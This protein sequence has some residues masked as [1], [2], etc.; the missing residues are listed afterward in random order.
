MRI[1]IID[2]SGVAAVTADPI[3]DLQAEVRNLKAQLTEARRQYYV[4]EAALVNIR[5]YAAIGLFE[6]DCIAG[7]K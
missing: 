3:T 2:A 7:R 5:K 4:A 6:Y 1:F